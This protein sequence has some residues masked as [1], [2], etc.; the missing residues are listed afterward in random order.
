MADPLLLPEGTRL[1]HIG[2]HKTGTT[3]VQHAFHHHRDAIAAHGVHYAG[4]ASQP[5]RPV[6][7]LTGHPGRRGAPP[8][9]EEDWRRLVAEVDA[10]GDQRV[11]ISS[12]SLANADRPAIERLV[13]DLGADRV[14]VVRMLRRYDLVMPSQWQQSVAGGMARSY[15]AWLEAV[16]ADPAHAFWRRHGYAE[17]TR[18]WVDVVG[19]ER[20]TLVVVDEGD[21]HHLLRVFE[22]LLGLPPQTLPLAEGRQ[23]RSLTRN[24]VEMLRAVNQQIQERHWDE[25]A[26]HRY[27]RLGATPALKERAPD[28]RDE[29]ISLTV[30]ATKVAANTADR[31][32][33]EVTA[34]GVRVVGS[35]DDLRVPVAA[36]AGRA[37]ATART[38]DASALVSPQAVAAATAGTIQAILAAR[39]FP[40]VGDPRDAPRLVRQL[41]VRRRPAVFVPAP[42]LLG[43]LARRA[44]RAVVRRRSAKP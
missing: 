43:M 1:V 8:V 32:I 6:V 31:G 36:V 28:V 11:L 24:E 19:P 39:R 42:A 40:L 20:V 14:H 9:V 7:A 30:A 5:Y 22:R 44:G 2:P 29:A 41:P 13:R 33:A 3:A 35:L 21:R 37:A 15:D 10:A 25:R 4:R 17:L 26:H 18:R 23:N 38:D 16:V 34:L 12:E 27:I